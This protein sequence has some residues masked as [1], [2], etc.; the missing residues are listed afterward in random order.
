MRPSIRKGP[1]KVPVGAAPTRSEPAMP[2]A[3]P[4]ITILTRPS[5]S[6]RPPMTTMKIPEKR[7]VIETAMFM[8]FVA[9]SRSA[10]IV[11]AMFNVV[12]ANSQKPSTPKMIP[13]RSRS[14]PR[15]SEVVRVVMASRP[16]VPESD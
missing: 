12:C 5:R 4:H 14:S 2:K 8:T 13:N 9:T 1:A 6:A 16:F 10:A 15:Y 3:N 7:A 11:G